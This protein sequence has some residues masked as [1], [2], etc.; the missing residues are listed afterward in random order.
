MSTGEQIAAGILFAAAGC[1]LFF[2]I[3]H[4]MEKGTLLNNAWFWASDTERKGLDKKPYYRQSAIVLCIL[5]AVFAVIG[6]SVVL[7]NSRICFAEIPLITAAVV[8]AAVSSAKIN[9]KS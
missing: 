8:Y 3:R 5:S 1:M 4:F 6:L 7:Q 9:R 2:G